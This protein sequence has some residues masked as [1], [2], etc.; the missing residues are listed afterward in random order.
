[1]LLAHLMGSFMTL[2][3]YRPSGLPEWAAGKVKHGVLP[4]MKKPKDLCP[5]LFTV[6]VKLPN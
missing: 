1:M 5:W 2:C 6:A 4:M 3:Q